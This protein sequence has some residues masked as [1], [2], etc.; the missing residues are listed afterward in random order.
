MKFASE[1]ADL[2]EDRR[3]FSLSLGERAGVRASISRICQRLQRQAAFANVSY[4][5]INVLARPHPDLLPQEKEQQ[6]HLLSK[7]RDWF[8]NHGLLKFASE[9][10]DLPED[11][12]RFSLSLGERTGVRASV[13]RICQRLP[14]E[15][16]FAN[17]SYSQ[18]NVLAR[19]Q[20]DLLPQEK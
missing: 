1:G 7:V 11:R 6:C 15:A 14:R 2:P 20:P 5:Q 13:S 9:G 18:I 12:R 16:A 19:P 8:S 4:S 17:V 3:R 10:A